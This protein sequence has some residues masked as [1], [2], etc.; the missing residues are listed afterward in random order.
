MCGEMFGVGGGM[1]SVIVRFVVGGVVG[2]V[3]GL[4]LTV[5]LLFL[6]EQLAALAL[7]RGNVARTW[8]R[9]AGSDAEVRQQSMI[10]D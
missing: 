1:G 7:N 3:V 6:A 8:P 5:A 9:I 4:T 10:K 2:G